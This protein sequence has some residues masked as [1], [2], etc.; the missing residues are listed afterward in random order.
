MSAYSA[1]CSTSNVL[2]FDMGG[3]TAKGSVIGDGVP[4]MPL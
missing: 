4:R 2:A 1:G 3:T